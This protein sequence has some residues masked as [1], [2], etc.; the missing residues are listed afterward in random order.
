M[1]KEKL[2]LRFTDRVQSQR[3][4]L[5]GGNERSAQK[6]VH[7]AQKIVHLPSVSHFIQYPAHNSVCQGRVLI[8]AHKK[9]APDRIGQLSKQADVEC[10]AFVGEMCFVHLG[11]SRVDQVAEVIVRIQPFVGEQRKRH[12]HI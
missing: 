10:F 8:G 1:E 11:R 4:C 3:I 7:D 6:N 12:R 9:G 5:H 2:E